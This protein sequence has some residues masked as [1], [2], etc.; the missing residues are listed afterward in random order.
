M[1]VIQA[2]YG[3]MSRVCTRKKCSK[4]YLLIYDAV[5]IKTYLRDLEKTDRKKWLKIVKIV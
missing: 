1:S 2:L 4:K 3:S 5:C